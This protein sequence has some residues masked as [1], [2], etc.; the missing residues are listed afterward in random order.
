MGDEVEGNILKIDRCSKHDGPGTRVVV[1][2]KGCPLS[3]LWCSTPDSQGGSSQL[4]HY[5]TL[6]AGCGRCAAACSENALELTENGIE[7]EHSIC[8]RCGICVKKCLNNAMRIVGDKMQVED[9]FRIVKKYEPF[10]VRMPGGLT[11]SG[12]EALFQYDFTLALLKMCHDEG[13]DTNIETS[14][15]TSEEKILALVPYLDHICCDVKH[16]DE[17]EHKK[18][19]GV[20]NEQIKS[21]IRLLSDKLDLILRYPVIPGC[22][23]SDA[24]VQATIEFIHTL[25]AKFNRIDLLA[26]HTMGV[27]TYRRLGRKYILEGVESLSGE[28]MKEIRQAMTDSGINAVLA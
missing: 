11:I 26:Y 20:S 19:T 23:D 16:M 10:W 8:T 6:C 12:G 22:N 28:R 1:F 15:F 14:C 17:A 5:E 2:L 7:V 27:P 9:V 18:L 25:G 24:N 4:I 21:N 3:C 13:I